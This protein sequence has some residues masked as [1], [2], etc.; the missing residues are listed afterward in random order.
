MALTPEEQKIVEYGKGQ[1]KS[2]TEV[3]RALANYRASQPKTAPEAQAPQAPGLAQIAGEKVAGGVGSAVGGFLDK[4]AGAVTKFIGAKPIADTYGTEIA[5]ASTKNADE[6]TILRQQAPTLKETAGSAIET[7]SM[8]IP[9]AGVGSSLVKKVA[10]GAVTGYGVDVG[11]KLQQD[12]S[13]TEAATPGLGTVT[14]ALLPVFGK[15]IG[16]VPKAM[17]KANLR[18]TPVEQQ[19]L[20]KRGKDIVGYLA[21]QKIVGTPAQRLQAVSKLYTQM[22]DKVTTAIANEGVA[23]PKAEI[24]DAVKDAVKQYADDPIALPE[25]NKAIDDFLS[26]LDKKESFAI[27]LVDIN[28]Y[29]RTIM[30]RAFSKNKAD[31][32]SEG[33]Y[34]V[35]AALKKLLDDEV[36]GLSKLNQE[37]SDIILARRVLAKASTRNQANLLTRTLAT[38]VG[39]AAGGTLGGFFGATVGGVAADRLA[40]TLATPLRSATGATVQTLQDVLS[41]LPVD[42]KGNIPAKLLIE[43]LTGQE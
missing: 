38:G 11:S 18:M 15:I 1:G 16:Q 41:K 29:K 13:L 14:G 43:A 25:V 30:E 39:A 35:G 20:L 42:E 12:K 22:E 34:A 33:R 4:A 32:V 8:L 36:P 6:K 9:G 21:K 2:N 40:N 3:M 5:A 10:L 7:G 37:Y 17:E 24:T 26:F 19:N 23:I 27:S 28:N 31:V